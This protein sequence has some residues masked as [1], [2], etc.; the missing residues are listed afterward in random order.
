MQ[1]TFTIKYIDDAALQTVAF[2][3]VYKTGVLTVR[4]VVDGRK[5]I[6]RIPVC[7]QKLSFFTGNF[8][9]FFMVFRHIALTVQKHLF[10]VGNGKGSG[11]A[12]QLLIGGK[13]VRNFC[14]SLG[15]KAFVF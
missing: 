4:A 9:H 13:P 6:L 3:A 14:L 8:L 15:Q 10:S 5:E 12:R 11:S 2:F 1:I 7:K